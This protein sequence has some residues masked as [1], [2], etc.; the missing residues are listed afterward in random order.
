VPWSFHLSRNVMKL[1]RLSESE[2]ISALRKDFPALQRK[3]LFGIGDDAAVLKAERD[4]LVVTKDLLIES[5]HF[6]REFGSAYLLGRKSLAVNLSDVAAMGGRPLYC[7]LGL[8]LPRSLPTTWVEDFM[9][10]FKSLCQ[11]EK[12]SLIGGDLSRSAKIVISVTVIGKAR[13]FVPRSGAR[14]GDT[15]WISGYPGLAAAGLYFLKKGYFSEKG[16]YFLR[17]GK[18]FLWQGKD[19]LGQGKDSQRRGKDFLEKEKNFIDKGKNDTIK[20]PSRADSVALLIKA[21]LEPEPKLRLGRWLAEQGLA[22]AMIDISDGLSID[23]HHICEESSVGAEIDLAKIPVHPA[24]RS[25]FRDPWP[26]IL[27]GGEDYEL[28][29]TVP[30]SKRKKVIEASRRYQLHEIGRMIAGQ[31]MWLLDGGRRRPLK[32]AGFTHFH[33]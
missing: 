17:R 31:G 11:E 33:P 9:A 22:T 27:H 18:N 14:P 2:L 7:L 3:I 23:L 12:V 32:P 19:I 16:K 24:L 26:F 10:G 13:K 21:F 30:P 8:G 29:F 15:I 25:N 6:K 4:L 1:S 5:T 20:V 28:L